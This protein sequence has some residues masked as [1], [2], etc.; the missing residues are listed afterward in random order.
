VFVEWKNNKSIFIPPG[1]AHGFQALDN[2]NYIVYS[3]TKYRHKKSETTINFNEKEFKIKWPN[4]KFVI[5]TKDKNGISLLEYK[6][7]YL[8]KKKF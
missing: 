2:E 8:W 6:K 5:S 4:K 3:C 1:F 7:K